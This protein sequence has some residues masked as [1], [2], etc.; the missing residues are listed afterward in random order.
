MPIM[1]KITI[2]RAELYTMIWQE[3][4]RAV[5]L[6]LGI[7]DVG[8]AKICRKLH[9]PRPWRGYWRKKETGHNPRQPKLPPWPSHLGKE[10]EPVTFGT[11]PAPGADA[12]ACPP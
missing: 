6:Q 1:D 5:A 4:T 9:I 8:L 10:P 11:K 12:T 3:P 2:S 7:S